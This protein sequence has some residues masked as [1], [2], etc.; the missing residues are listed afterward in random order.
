ME[1]PIGLHRLLAEGDTAVVILNGN[2]EPNE[3]Q[4]LLSFFYEIIQ[5]HGRYATITDCARMG[6]LS[7][8][9]RALVAHWK[10]SHLCFGNALVGAGLAARAMILLVT[11]GLNLLSSKSVA[12]EFFKSEPEARAWIQGLRPKEEAAPRAPVKDR[13]P[14]VQR[15]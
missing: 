14:G 8:R 6:K 10:H 3:M 9:A 5:R 12:I 13:S 2:V 7:P 1:H 15:P 4:L 11:R